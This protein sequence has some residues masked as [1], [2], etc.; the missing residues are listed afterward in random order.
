MLSSSV[1]KALEGYIPSIQALACSVARCS[2]ELSSRLHGR[3]EVGRSAPSRARSDMRPFGPGRTTR[4]VN[5][6]LAE[7]RPAALLVDRDRPV[8]EG[9]SVTQPPD[10]RAPR[11]ARP[12]PP[13]KASLRTCERASADAKHPP[14]RRGTRSNRISASGLIRN[15]VRAE[16]VGGP[17]A[18]AIGL[19]RW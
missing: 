5:Y 1:G 2:L 17:A 16:Q 6:C 9:G 13:E 4:R 11:D 14:Q 7:F 10:D 12:T 3:P 8:L 15:T 18:G 19:K